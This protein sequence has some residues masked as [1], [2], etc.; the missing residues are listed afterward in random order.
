MTF[1]SSLFLVA[2][3]CASASAH[4]DTF[5]V[6]H[7]SG[8]IDANHA[9]ACGA[10]ESTRLLTIVNEV[11]SIDVDQSVMLM[12]LNADHIAKSILYEADGEQFASFTS[13]DDHNVEI[14]VTLGRTPS[15][16]D[17]YLLQHAGDAT[18][19][20]PW[21]TCYTHWRGLVMEAH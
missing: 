1:T 11:R 18:K 13:A 7:Q 4:A 19:H 12:H 2:A 15:Q 21:N 16:I 20:T 9:E 8:G 6:S 5:T 14:L 3:L 17:V 10:D